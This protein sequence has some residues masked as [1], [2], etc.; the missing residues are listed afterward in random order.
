MITKPPL[1]KDLMASILRLDW[2]TPNGC[3][4]AMA[5]LTV[6]KGALHKFAPFVRR[7]P[8]QMGEIG[9]FQQQPALGERNR[10]AP[11]PRTPASD[12]S[13]YHQIQ[14]G[15][16][17]VRDHFEPQWLKESLELL[18]GGKWLNKQIAG[19]SEL[20]NEGTPFGMA[21]HKTPT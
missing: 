3:S 4:K 11:V 18:S 1:G 19:G 21:D 5:C 20:I 14:L 16:I 10:R 8:G 2:W 15:F 7:E 6:V 12:L 9:I 13:G 17:S